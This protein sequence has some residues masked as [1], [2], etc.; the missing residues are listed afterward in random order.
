MEIRL[1]DLKVQTAVCCH[2]LLADQPFL[3]ASEPTS[4][5]RVVYRQGHTAAQNKL[6]FHVFHADLSLWAVTCL[7]SLRSLTDSLEVPFL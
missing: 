1:L 3:L 7:P 5:P 6:A 2:G 4:Q